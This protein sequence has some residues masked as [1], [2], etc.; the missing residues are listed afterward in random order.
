MD[1]AYTPLQRTMCID[2]KGFH[3]RGWTCERLFVW[4]CS[5]VG[6]VPSFA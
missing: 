6:P 1:V 3:E 4:N 2:G 5:D